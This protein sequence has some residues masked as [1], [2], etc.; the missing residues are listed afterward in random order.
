M[1]MLAAGSPLPS[2]TADELF[3]WLKVAVALVAIATMVIHLFRML[4][5]EPPVSAE[6][7][8]KIAAAMAPLAGISAH[9]DARISAALAPFDHRLATL[10]S[11]FASL[12]TQI[13]VDLANIHRAGEER[14]SKIHRR[15]DV[16]SDNVS[17]TEGEL[18]Q[19]A[20][21]VKELLR[22]AIGRGH[23]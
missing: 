8:K 7:D 12:R 15:I 5:R 18:K 19:V 2:P 21:N 13:A 3:A 17:I 16:I 1:L 9:V 20:A 11:N 10:E 4:R 23:S 6:I 14:A 22:L